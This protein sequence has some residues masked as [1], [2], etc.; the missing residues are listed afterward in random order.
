MA[1]AEVQVPTP[2]RMDFFASPDSMTTPD[3]TMAQQWKTPP[4][5]PIMAAILTA[6]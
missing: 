4:T 6:S 1:E 3:T 2:Q 5:T